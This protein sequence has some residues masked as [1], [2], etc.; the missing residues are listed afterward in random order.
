MQYNSKLSNGDKAFAIQ[1][2]CAGVPLIATLT[3]GK[4]IIEDTK[5]PGLPN[6][7]VFDNYKAKNNYVERYMCVETGIGTGSIYEYGKNIF[8]N[9]DACEEAILSYLKERGF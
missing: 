2:T 7:E 9:A 1:F 8:D 4:V 5:S 3:I 6:E